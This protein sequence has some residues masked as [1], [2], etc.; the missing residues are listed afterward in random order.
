MIIKNTIS[1]LEEQL[2]IAMLT[3]DIAALDLLI[4]PA[5]IFTNHMG[6]KISKAD[7]LEIHRSGTLK[8]YQLEPSEQQTN[9]QAN[10]AIVSVR[11]KTL[12][13]YSGA[14]F[15]ADLRFTRVWQ[16]SPTGQWQIIAGHSSEV[17]VF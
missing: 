2:R 5:L 9:I 17:K 13:T 4:S 14:A 11:M 6:Q 7:D 16:I 10:L 8:F 15:A 1:E 3:G 12:G